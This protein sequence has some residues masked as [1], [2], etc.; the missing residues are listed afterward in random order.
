MSV[1]DIFMGWF[2]V[3]GCVLLFVAGVDWWDW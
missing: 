1:E 3:I 2:V